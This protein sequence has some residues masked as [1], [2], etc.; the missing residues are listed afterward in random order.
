MAW[1]T[2]TTVS[3][4]DVLTASRYNADVQA[5][6]TELAPLFAAWT[7]HS[8]VT[9]TQT[10]AITTTANY[11]KYVKIG[12]LVVWNFKLTYSSGTGANTALTVTLPFS[13]ASSESR[14]IGSGGFFDA[15]ASTNYNGSW[16]IASAST[17][18]L[19]TDATGAQS[20]GN[21]PAVTITTSDLFHGFVIYEAAS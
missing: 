5:N 15:S 20:F 1:I 10:N 21:T 14:S 11:S 3:T 17:I 18:T 12:R 2:P 19:T 4:G 9:V 7:T 8:P 6:L 16:Y 13:S